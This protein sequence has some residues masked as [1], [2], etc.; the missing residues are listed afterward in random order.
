MTGLGM[1][2]AGMGTVLEQ[3]SLYHACP[4]TELGKAKGDGRRS[5]DRAHRLGEN[6]PFPSHRR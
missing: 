1:G 2:I 4:G 3:A 5:R 6:A